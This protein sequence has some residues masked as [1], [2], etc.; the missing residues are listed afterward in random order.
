MNKPLDMF[1]REEEIVT[2]MLLYRLA[3]KEKITLRGY[4]ADEMMELCTEIGA[5]VVKHYR[6]GEDGNPYV[7]HEAVSVNSPINISKR[8][9][10]KVWSH[11]TGKPIPQVDEPTLEISEYCNEG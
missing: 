6:L 3:E 5:A 9:V 4:S 2:D 1:L 10:R 7:V 11:L 8:I